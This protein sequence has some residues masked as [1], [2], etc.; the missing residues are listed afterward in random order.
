MK[1]NP[2]QYIE[3]TE[4]DYYPMAETDDHPLL[5]RIMAEMDRIKRKLFS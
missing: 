4:R 2:F 1:R 5:R 3:E